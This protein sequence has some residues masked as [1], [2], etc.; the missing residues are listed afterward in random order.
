MRKA[1]LGRFYKSLED[2]KNKQKQMNKLGSSKYS[3]LEITNGYIV[4][5]LGQFNQLKK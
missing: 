5:S 2:A 1:V 3:I 4:M